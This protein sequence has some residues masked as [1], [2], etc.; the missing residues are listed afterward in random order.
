MVSIVEVVMILAGREDRIDGS[1]RANEE[2][3]RC[4]RDWS[5]WY[6]IVVARCGAARVLGEWMNAL[7]VSLSNRGIL[8]QSS[9]LMGSKMKVQ[10]KGL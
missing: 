1:G 5:G 7:K 10:K 8:V 4:S 9:Y 3:S 6:G 2:A